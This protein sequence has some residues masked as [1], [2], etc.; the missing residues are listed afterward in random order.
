MGPTWSWA[1]VETITRTGD[2]RVYRAVPFDMSNSSLV[3]TD[4]GTQDT[5]SLENLFTQKD[6]QP[7]NVDLWGIDVELDSLDVTRMSFHVATGLNQPERAQIT[8][9]LRRRSH[10]FAPNGV[11]FFDESWQD[12]K[13]YPMDQSQLIIDAL[14]F[15]RTVTAILVGTTIYDIVLQPHPKQVRRDT[16]T[17]RALWIPALCEST[18]AGFKIYTD[19]EYQTIENILP[20]AAL[21]KLKCPL[22]NKI[23]KTPVSAADGYT[24]EKEAILKHMMQSE[25]SP[26]TGVHLLSSVLRH[27]H[28]IRELIA[29]MIDTP[30]A[31]EVSKQKKQQKKQLKKRSREGLY[32]GEE[33]SQRDDD[34][35]HPGI[36]A[37]RSLMPKKKLSAVHKAPVFNPMGYAPAGEDDA[38][39]VVAA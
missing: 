11:M 13:P 14:Q 36:K 35:S 31:K 8:G 12:Y 2:T 39:T 5:I 33:E 9:I 25:T 32:N 26:V 21:E 4:F 19:K 17:V 10:L 1:R 24:Y 15:G 37:T 38:Q 23:M 3:W 34:E 30:V 7:V 6:D 20:E 28:T 27:N 18:L 16:G 29:S 22:T